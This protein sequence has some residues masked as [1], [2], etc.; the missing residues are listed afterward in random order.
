MM[1]IRESRQISMKN[2]FRRNESGNAW[3]EA[4]RAS[5]FSIFAPHLQKIIEMTKKMAGYTN[6]GEEVYDV[7]LNQF[8]EGMDSA[9]IEKA[10]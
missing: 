7:L 1:R 8:E 9:T 3:K 2:S 4:K 5:D 6:P 10:F